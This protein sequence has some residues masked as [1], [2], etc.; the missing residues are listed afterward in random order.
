MLCL[1]R[2][3]TEPTYK[4]VPPKF[5]G[6]RC[7]S[8]LF[9]S[10]LIL[11]LRLDFRLSSPLDMTISSTTSSR[12]PSLIPSEDTTGTSHALRSK[13]NYNVLHTVQGGLFRPIQGDLER[14]SHSLE[15]DNSSQPTQD[16]NEKAEAFIV[17]WDGPNDPDNP[18]NWSNRRRWT[19]TLVVSFF[20]FIR[21][22]LPNDT[23]RVSDHTTSPVGSSISSPALP[24]ISRDL[25][26]PPGSVLENMSLSI[27]VLA[28]ALGVS[29]YFCHVTPRLS[30]KSSP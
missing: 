26:I 30:R 28:Y 8:L 7:T 9:Q 13:H 6:S 20:T 19:V 2:E 3:L 29:T 25:N 22:E 5:G 11:V 18:R 10:R 27:F 17:T 12:V 16:H 21:Y 1:P 14:S 23:I 15:S 24:Q 4:D